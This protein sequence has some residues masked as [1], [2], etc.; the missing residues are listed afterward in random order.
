V[1]TDKTTALAKALHDAG[2]WPDYPHWADPAFRVADA[3]LETLPANGLEVRI[4][5]E[6]A[7]PRV[8]REALVAAVEVAFR[9]AREW[10]R[11]P[12]RLENTPV[13]PYDKFADAILTALGDAKDGEG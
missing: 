4:I 8:D 6:G 13:W 11:H 12:N 10:V 3:L 2:L 1:T 5:E 9:E 7:E